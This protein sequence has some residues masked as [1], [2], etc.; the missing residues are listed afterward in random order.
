ME[1]SS[2]I[3]VTFN[4][5]GLAGL[6][7]EEGGRVAPVLFRSDA[8]ASL[9]PVGLQALADLRIGTVVDMRTDAER[10]RA[11]NVLPADGSVQLI[12]L[13]VLGGAMDEMVQQLLPAAGASGE[14]SDEQ[15]VAIAKQVPTLAELYVGILGSSAEQ[16]VTLARAVLAAT[17]TVRPGLLFHCTA[18]KDRT[19]LAAALL[20]SVAGVPRDRIVADYTQTEANLAGRFAQTLTG[21]ITSLGIPMTPQLETLATKSPADA[22][23]AALDWIAA[24]HGDARGYLSSG[25]L[26]AAEA[27][28]LG[29]VLVNDR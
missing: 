5:R 21:L 22:I 12:N 9:T 19:G 18:G 24:E 1:L 11:P 29:R 13:P 8:L 16:F 17:A 2:V 15:M 25:G 23:E 26:S 10:L 27:T 14:L 28:E 20:L 7:T 3:Q 4:A 6:P